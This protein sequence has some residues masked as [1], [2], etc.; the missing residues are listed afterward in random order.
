MES[1]RLATN[2]RKGRLFEQRTRNTARHATRTRHLRR[3]YTQQSTSAAHE[4]CLLA[5]AV[6]LAKQSTWAAL[7]QSSTVTL[8]L[9]DLADG[10]M[11]DQ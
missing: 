1:I 8:F 11:R 4:T 5:P 2:R 3:R 10:C 9:R 6:V 7:L